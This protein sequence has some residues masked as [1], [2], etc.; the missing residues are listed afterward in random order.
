MKRVNSAA[1]A[2]TMTDYDK[3]AARVSPRGS[4]GGIQWLSGSEWGPSGPGLP[5]HLLVRLA[6]ARTASSPTGFVSALFALFP[7]LYL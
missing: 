5:Q 3:S 6:R 1:V 7:Y 4:D 2:W